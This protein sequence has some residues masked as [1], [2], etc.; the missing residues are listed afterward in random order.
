MKLFH[1]N[2]I[3]RGFALLLVLFL[4]TSTAYSQKKGKKSTG[5]STAS[6]AASDAYVF[7]YFVGNGEDGLHFAYST[8]GLNWQNVKEGKSLL[9][10][11]VGENKLMRDP[12]IAQGPDGMYHMV[13]TTSWQGKTI[14]YA[15]SKDLINWSEQQAI[16]VMAHEPEVQNCWAPEI[17]YDAVS[18]S[19]Y[20]YWA[21][22]I[23]G[24]FPE[25]VKSHNNGE[26][27][28]H[29][30]YAT[31]T[32]DFKTYTPTKLFYE[33]GFNVIDASIVSNGKGFVMFLKDE[34]QL[35]QAK[36]HILVTQ[37]KSINGPWAKVDKPITGADYWA[38]GPTAVKIKDT[39]YVYFDKYTKHEYGVVTSTDL[40]NW[41]D[42]SAKLKVPQGLRHG[43][44]VGVSKKILDALLAL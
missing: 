20:I 29:R 21:S 38:E 8:D 23:L 5:T 31:T 32:K 33:P 27:L 2:Y 24:K 11:V 1:L 14:G 3:H 15:S 25:T 36:K 6:K 19:F 9:T 34:T 26:K 28:N 7:S 4:C 10:P 44:V 37:S 22:T 30:I 39:W 17:T 16:P 13:W 43:T 12:C 18:K 40:V 35:P 42:E 41:T